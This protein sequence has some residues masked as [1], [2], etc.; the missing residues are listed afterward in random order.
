MILKSIYRA[1]A[2]WSSAILA[3]IV[4]LGLFVLPVFLYFSKD[5]PDYHQL[6]QYDPPTIS[7]IYSSEGDLMAELAAERRIF[8]KINEIP[9]VIINAFIS[10]EDQNYYNHPG[11]DVASIIR[12]AL[13]NLGNIGSEKHPV[14]GS[15]IT[16]Q[17]VKN[18]LLTNERSMSRKI[19]EAILA[20]RINTVYS[21]DRILELYLNQIYLGN[22]AYGVTSAALSYFNKDLK[23]VTLEEAALLA[24]LP[25]APSLLDPSRYPQKAKPRRDWVLDRMYEE[26]FITKEQAKIGQSKPIS[27]NPRFESSIL[28]NGYYTESVRLELIE[29]YGY[30]Q[31]YKDGFSIYTNLNKDLQKYADESLREGLIEYDHRHGYVKPTKSIKGSMDNWKAALNQLE[32]PDGAGT[33]RL[34]AVLSLTDTSVSIGF[35]DGNKGSIPLENLKWARKRLSKGY[36]GKAIERPSDVLSVGDIILVGQ[37]KDNGTH[38]LEQIPEVNGALVVIQPRTG[39]VLAMSGGYSFKESKYNRALQAMRQPGSAFKPFV[40]LAALEKGYGPTSIVKDEPIT[41]SQGPDKPAWTPKNFEGKFLYAITLRKALEKSRNLA[42]VYTITKVGAR[43]VGDLATRLQIYDKSPPAYYSMALGAVE[44]T[45]M[46]LT[47]AYAAFASEGL[48]VNY[49]LIDRVQDRKGNLIYTSDNRSCDAC[50]GSVSPN[51]KPQ[52]SYNAKSVIDPLINYQ[53]VSMLQGAVERGTGARAKKI[54]KVVAG[55]TGTSNESNDTWFIGFTPDLVVGVFVG[56]DAPKTLGDKEQGSTAALP[57]FVKFMERALKAM[58]SRE[59]PIPAE[60]TFVDSDYDTGAP[61]S[62]GFRSTII[63]EPMKPGFKPIDAIGT[64]TENSQEGS[65]WDF[66]GGAEEQH[67]VNQENQNNKAASRNQDQDSNDGW[68]Y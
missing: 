27:L 29:K 47:A 2:F 35:K 16:Q 53:I 10:A 14:G 45:P 17:V 58:P 56:Y 28:N 54:G 39:K 57:I 62:F 20:Y 51:D 9:E 3:S 22:G 50:T 19:K 33:W 7:R 60:I 8:R 43:S 15:T 40:Y 23:N 4:L 49:K 21:K 11:I 5:L 30:D 13:Q 42:T 44:T 37:N 64:K 12:A 41:I 25:K 67:D 38:T 31:I 48:L 55:K 6:T 1:L 18:F 61:A 36:T 52:L 65:P 26:G 34:A 66:F 24:A 59:F 63:K 32:T 68:L 46:R